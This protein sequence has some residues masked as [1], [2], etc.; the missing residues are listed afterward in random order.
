MEHLLKKTDSKKVN[1]ILESILNWD[2]QAILHSLDSA[3]TYQ[4]LTPKE[5][6]S[7][8]EKQFMHFKLRG[9][10]QL[11][12]STNLCQGCN[13]K[14]PMFVFKGNKS[15]REYALYFEFDGD[16]ILDIYRCNWYGGISFDE[17]SFEGK[18]NLRVTF[19]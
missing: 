4:N 18:D 16:E 11:L 5:F 17:I 19:L 2:C 7:T 8:I 1:Q 12:L 3:K 10:T 15:G 14:Q 6:V 13:C 9:D